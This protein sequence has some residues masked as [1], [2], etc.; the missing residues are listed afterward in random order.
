MDRNTVSKIFIKLVAGVAATLL[1]GAALAEPKLQLDID[2]G[3][4]DTTSEDVVISSS[5]FTVLALCDVSITTQCTDGGVG[6]FFFVSIS[7]RDSDGNAVAQTDP[8]LGY[9]VVN[10]D[11][12]DVTSEMVYGEPPADQFLLDG[13]L[14]GHGAFPTYFYELGVDFIVGDTCGAA[15]YNVQETPGDCDRSGTA[16]YFYEINVDVSNL[17]DG[18]GLHFDLYNASVMVPVCDTASGKCATDDN[19]DYIDFLG[20]SAELEQ[21]DVAKA[22]F[23][24]DASYTCC[25]KK[26]PEPG[27]L[28]LLGIGLLGLGLTRRRQI[29]V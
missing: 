5:T 17:A 29:K 27:T 6:E 2:G 4:Y 3:T 18:Y 9:I 15:Q 8:D 10:D 28:A 21:G 14:P 26:V 22:P 23:S 7:L 12:I 16:S 25:E 20:Y 24:K 1:S 19:G 13:D 11:Q